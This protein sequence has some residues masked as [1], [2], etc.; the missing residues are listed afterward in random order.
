MSAICQAARLREEVLGWSACQASSAA[1]SSSSST[2]WEVQATLTV[3]ISRQKANLISRRSKSIEKVK[4]LIWKEYNTPLV[5]FQQ[6][7]GHF[8]SA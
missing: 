6:L 1:R 2:A 5:E 4:F 8:Y 7:R 3:S